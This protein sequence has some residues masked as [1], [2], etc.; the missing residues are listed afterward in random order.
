[1]T[2]QDFDFYLVDIAE[3][4]IVAGSEG[5]QTGTQPPVEELLLAEHAPYLGTFALI[6]APLQRE[7]R[8]A[9]RHV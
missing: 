7:H 1:M 9:V 4:E 3:F 6:V 8:T 2:D 5:F